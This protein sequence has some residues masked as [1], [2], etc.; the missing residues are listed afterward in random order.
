MRPNPAPH[1]AVERSARLCLSRWLG[2]TETANFAKL[3]DKPGNVEMPTATP[4]PQSSFAVVDQAVMSEADFRKAVAPP[5]D[6]RRKKHKAFVFVH[7]FNNNFQESLFRLA[8]LQADMKIDG[9]PIL[10]SWPSQGQVAAYET[11]KESASYSRDYLMALLTMLTSSPEVSDIL[12]V[13]HSMGARLTA[14]GIGAVRSEYVPRRTL[15]LTR[16]RHIYLQ[17]L[18]ARRGRHGRQHLWTRSGR[19]TDQNEGKQ[20]GD[21]PVYSATTKATPHR[22]GYGLP[23]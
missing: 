1:Q 19:A 8:Q 4:D 23:H 21:C 22:H 18:C 12:V 20:N 13:A 7:G 14:D 16:G 5:G 11:D 15:A 9:I 3:S 2:G 6:A 10:F 17:R